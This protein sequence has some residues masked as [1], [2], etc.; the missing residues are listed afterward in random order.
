MTRGRQ[1]ALGVPSSLRAL[2][3]GAWG[4]QGGAAVSHRA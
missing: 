3:A 2:R 4:C 1:A